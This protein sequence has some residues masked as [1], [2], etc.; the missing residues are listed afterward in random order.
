MDTH[1]KI[2]R[3]HSDLLPRIYQ[4]LYNYIW[5][6]VWVI[7]LPTFDN[8]QL[9][10]CELTQWTNIWCHHYHLFRTALPFVSLF[11]LHEMKYIT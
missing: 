8:S 1:N 4:I 6:F 11:Q 9:N 3:F 5:G 10:I 2:S 7:L